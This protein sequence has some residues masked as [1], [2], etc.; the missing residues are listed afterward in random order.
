MVTLPSRNAP[1]ARSGTTW[2]IS[3][4][5]PRP[6]LKISDLGEIASWLETQ[7]SNDRSAQAAFGEMLI[8]D[9]FTVYAAHTV[10]VK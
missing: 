8:V 10:E 9:D 6:A 5:V 4:A 2:S 7:L 1:P 3:L